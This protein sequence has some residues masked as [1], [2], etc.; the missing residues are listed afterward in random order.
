MDN[1]LVRRMLYIVLWALTALS[2]TC[3]CTKEP[4]YQTDPADIPD[5]S[6]LITVIYDPD[7]LGDRSYNDLIYKGVEDAAKEYGLRTMQLAP[8]S[9]EEGFAYLETVFSQM[10]SIQ[11]TV[12]RLFIVTSPAYDEFLR[13]NNK[14]LEASPNTDLLYLETTTPLDG[15]GSTLMLPYYGA[16]YEA[17]ALSSILYDSALLVGANPENE[18]VKEAMDGF[19]DGYDRKLITRYLGRTQEEGFSVTDS[20]ALKLLYAE[21]EVTVTSLVIP[22]CGGAGSTLC[23]LVDIMGSLHY[24]G[25]DVDR[26]SRYCQIS[27]VKHIDKAVSLC[28]D[29]WMSPGGMPKHQSFGLESGY[30]EVMLHS[31]FYESAKDEGVEITDEYRNRI[32][33][34]AIEKEAAYEK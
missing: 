20:T 12:R 34:E 3:A 13:K 18:S 26:S 22:V 27:A 25:I 8:A 14:R 32:H 21:D 24:M 10:P 16:M 19:A 31:S 5:T 33:R 15:K 2:F 30:I 23:R 17:G 9:M 6:P 29:Q 7:A 28:I 11:D 4:L 1:A